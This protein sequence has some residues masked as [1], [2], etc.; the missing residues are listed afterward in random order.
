MLSRTQALTYCFQNKTNQKQTSK[1]NFFWSSWISFSC[2]HCFGEAEC[3]SFSR[4]NPHV[5]FIICDMAVLLLLP[6]QYVLL[7]I[8]SYLVCFHY[9]HCLFCNFT[10]SAQKTH[11]TNTRVPHRTGVKIYLY[12]FKTVLINFFQG[13]RVTSHVLPATFWGNHFFGLSP[14]A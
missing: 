12:Q 2:R 7:E 4:R 6:A 3:K 13:A 11:K 5:V 14:V 10:A 8:W 1:K 9:C